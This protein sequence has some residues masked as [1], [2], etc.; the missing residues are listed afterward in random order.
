MKKFI[1]VM[2]IPSPYRLHLLGELS[3]QLTERG[4]DFHCHFMAKGHAD[5]PKS[6]LN[7]KIDFPHTYWWDAG[8]GQHHFNP[9]L[10]L[11]LLFSCPDYLMCGS[12]FDTFTG[13]LIQLFSPARVK[14]CWLEGNTKTPGKLDGFI[15]WFKRLVIGHCQWAPVPGSDAAKYIGLHQARTGRKM[16][17]PVFL[18]NLVDERRFSGGDSKLATSGER[19]CLI[20]ARLEPVKGLVPFLKALNAEWLNGWKIFILGQGSL[21]G[22]IVALIQERQL[23]DVVSIV[24]Y[25]PYE[26]MPSWYARADLVLLPSLYDPNPLT[27]VEALHAGKALAVSCMAGNVEEAV[28]EGRNGWVLPVDEADAFTEKL[29]VVFATSKERLS[30]MGRL[31]HDE[32]AQ[33]WNTETSL[34]KFLNTVIV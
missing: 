6:W 7:P 27:C 1:A 24:D 21:K 22:E 3:R 25:V 11:K 8:F 31:S 18:P 5:R 9:C 19:L 15:G 2:N 34:A 29:K 30:Q 12:S 14:L 23:A 20:P 26:E 33:F 16:P 4:I 13:I 28:T 32:N 17:T 10:V